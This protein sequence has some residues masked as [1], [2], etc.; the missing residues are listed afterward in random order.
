MNTNDCATAAPASRRTRAANTASAA[1]PASATSTATAPP[2]SSRNAANPPSNA[3]TLAQIIAANTFASPARRND[4][5]RRINAVVRTATAPG[6]GNRFANDATTVVCTASRHAN[7]E[8][9]VLAISRNSA[10]FNAI[11]NG[12]V[13]TTNAATYPHA[14]PSVSGNERN[15][16][17]ANTANNANPNT[18]NAARTDGRFAA[19]RS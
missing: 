18:S 11:V 1:A 14:K 7:G 19:A 10:A 9:A 2:E 8:P 17:T 13:T 3:A 12:V 5:P 6:N 4:A 15:A 16:R